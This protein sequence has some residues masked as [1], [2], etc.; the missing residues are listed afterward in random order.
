[1]GVT[2]KRAV[3]IKVLVTEDFKRHRCVEIEQAISRLD[4]ATKRVDF[5]IESL[6]RRCEK[7]SPDRERVM[8][9]L[10]QVKRRNERARKALERELEIVRSLEIGSEYDRGVV[11]GLVD[12]SVGDDFA[13]LASCEIVVKDD[14]IVEIREGQCLAKDERS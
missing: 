3:R 1:M 10:S 12:V 6:R 8:E 9:R 14:R 2:I 11:E 4:E 13:K 7:D 5:E